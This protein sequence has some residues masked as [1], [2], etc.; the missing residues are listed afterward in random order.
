MLFEC[1]IVRVGKLDKLP[2][3]D[4]LSI[5]SVFGEIPVIVKT[6]SLKEGDT[7]VYIPEESL[8]PMDKPWFKGVIKTDKA[9]HR[10]KAVRLRGTYSEGLLIPFKGMLGADMAKEWGVTHYVE[11]EEISRPNGTNGTNGSRQAKD[12]PWAPKYSVESIFKNRH[13][14]PE[15]AKVEVT[16]KIHGCSFRATF[17]DKELHVGSHNTWKKP[18]Y[19]PINSGKLAKAWLAFKLFVNRFVKVFNLTPINNDVWWQ[20][21]LDLDLASKLKSYP[22]YVLY[23]EVYGKVQDLKYGVN[24][25]RFRAFDIYNA[26]TKEWESPFTVLTICQNLGI[27]TVPTLYVGPYSKEVDELRHGQS[28]LDCGTIREGIVI[29]LCDN[30]GKNTAL[31]YVSEGYKL[32]KN[33]TEGK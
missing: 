32:R 31:K 9:I 6:G 28:T 2:N 10:V 3:S 20:T 14:I 24:G 18:I 13:L 26:N 21:A 16:E 33:G 1:P 17:T 27:E 15:G 7:A 5:T 12:I 8:I 11:P 30:K 29:K 25:I 22:K 19:I 4:T 23:G